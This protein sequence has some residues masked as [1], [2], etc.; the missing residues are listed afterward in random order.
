MNKMF[1]AQIIVFLLIT[2][3]LGGML[4]TTD[5]YDDVESGVVSVLCLSC[6]KLEPKTSHD[7]TF[8]TANNEKHPDFVLEN[9]SY[10]PVL[11]H[12][13][14]DACEGCDEMLPVF[15]KYFDISFEKEEQVFQRFNLHNSTITYIYI[16]IDNDSVSKRMRNSW[17]IYDK[18][19]IGGMP[20]FVFITKE[21]H[22]SGDIKPFY[23]TLYGSF[24]QN[25]KD[26]LQYL[27]KLIV[28]TMRIY[29]R[30]KPK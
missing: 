17:K 7:Y 30:N 3:S 16:Y 23:T 4:V 19:Q 27:D 8:T 2:V 1:Y 28:E 22:H 5:V 11:L 29:D 24:K 14:Q 9:L 10:G 12:F 25:E 26:R 18:D 21:Y 15:Q 6:I 13:S 20:L